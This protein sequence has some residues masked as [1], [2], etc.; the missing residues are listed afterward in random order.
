[1]RADRTERGNKASFPACRFS[2]FS[3]E[4]IPANRAISSLIK[5]APR[6]WRDTQGW[7]GIENKGNRDREFVGVEKGPRKGKWQYSLHQT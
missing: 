3:R 6:W 1:M 5:L 4:T 7:N 2:F